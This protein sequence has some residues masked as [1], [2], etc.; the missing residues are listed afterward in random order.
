MPSTSQANEHQIISLSNGM[1]FSSQA[2]EG[3]NGKWQ[4]LRTSDHNQIQAEGVVDTRS[5][6]RRNFPGGGADGYCRGQYWME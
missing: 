4:M 1:E 3:K 2:E 6:F 5:C